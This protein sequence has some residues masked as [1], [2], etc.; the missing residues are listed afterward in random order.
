[1][2]RNNK[3]RTMKS[4]QPNIEV[5][6]KPNAHFV[7]VPVWTVERSNDW[8]TCYLMTMCGVWRAVWRAVWGAVW[9]AVWGAVW[10]AV[11]RAVWGAVWGGVP[12]V[13]KIFLTIMS[14]NMR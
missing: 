2:L 5:T 3:R 13:C 8:L 12:A 11:W 1:M 4:D 10:G 7:W 6:D 14:D 9:S